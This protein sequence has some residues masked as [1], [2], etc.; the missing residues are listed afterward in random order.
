M[1]GVPDSTLGCILLCLSSTPQDPTL[2]M[3]C[4]A[5]CQLLERDN[6]EKEGEQEADEQ[7]IEELPAG[8]DDDD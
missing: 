8:D 6:D 7:E 1:G 3:L 2:Q 4:I 5:G